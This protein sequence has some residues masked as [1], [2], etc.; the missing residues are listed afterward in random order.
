ML[1]TITRYIRRA[2]RFIGSLFGYKQFN[3][4][5]TI[6]FRGEVSFGEDGAIVSQTP[7]KESGFT[8]KRTDTPHVYVAK[9]AMPLALKEAY[10]TMRA[11]KSDDAVS[12]CPRFQMNSLFTTQRFSFVKTSTQEN[13]LPIN[14][15]SVELV[16]I[17]TPISGAMIR[18]P[19]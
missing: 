5:G 9:Y 8:V 1:S 15:T 10:I 13:A 19:K 3:P 18:E 7:P 12:V 6:I 4:P 17:G 11:P 2:I 16:F 14:G